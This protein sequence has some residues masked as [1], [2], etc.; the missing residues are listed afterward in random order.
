MHS[1]IPPLVSLIITK[2][3]KPTAMESATGRLFRAI[4]DFDE[5][6][7]R[8]CLQDTDVNTVFENGASPLTLAV[9]D[10]GTAIIDVLI[11]L[12]EAGADANFVNSKS[13][14]SSPIH[15]QRAAQMIKALLLC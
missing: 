12:L 5:D 1:C 2:S 8:R 3:P 10:G 9:D 6:A 14:I 15:P 4:R 7:V 13:T 11:I